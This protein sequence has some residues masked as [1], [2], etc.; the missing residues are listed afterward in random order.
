MSL[1]ELVA[2]AAVHEHTS[3]G[4]LPVPLDPLVGAG[5]ASA[6][7]DQPTVTFAPATRRSDGVFGPPLA[8]DTPLPLGAGP[9][10]L[11]DLDGDADTDVVVGACDALNVTALRGRGDGTFER[12]AELGT[13]NCVT[14][15]RV[16]DV[17]GD[18]VPD[19]VASTRGDAR[20][21]GAVVW[22]DVGR[23]SARVRPADTHR[24]GRPR[25]PRAA[26]P[27]TPRAA[28]PNAGTT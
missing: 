10:A 2:S 3:G 8:L 20:E 12:I 11:N 27:T 13:N 24:G 23:A 5:V 21:G 1:G 7:G 25:T 6:R 16:L 22:P 28:V 4:V 14:R 17:H 19:I 9:L 18:G 26:T 15:V